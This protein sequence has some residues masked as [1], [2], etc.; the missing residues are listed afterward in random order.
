MPIDWEQVPARAMPSGIDATCAECFGCEGRGCGYHYYDHWM[1]EVDNWLCFNEPGAF[2]AWETM[3]ECDRILEVYALDDPTF[4]DIAVRI[5][6][7]GMV[8]ATHQPS[9]TGR[10]NAS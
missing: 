3:D 5:R 2:E 1:S 4:G 7:F 8:G 9:N 6:A 10:V